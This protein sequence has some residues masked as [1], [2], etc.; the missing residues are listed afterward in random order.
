[1]NYRATAP[2]T[3][4]PRR[5]HLALLCAAALATALTACTGG[6]VQGTPGAAG[7]RDPYFPKL[8]NGGYDVRHYGLKLGYDPGSRHLTGTAE[9]TARA[10]KNLSAFNL[11][12]KGLDVRS[13]TVEGRKARFQRAGDELTV[14]P[15]EDLDRGETFRV[16]V[17]YSGTPRTI[18]DADGS[19]EG[20]LPA[21]DSA[22]ATGQPTGSMAWFPGNHHPSDKASYDIEVTV[23]KGLKA[24]SNGELTRQ[25]TSGGRT[26]FAWRNA[27]PMASY[28]ATVVVGDYDLKAST[29]PGKHGVPVL[30]AIDPT[31]P[32][33]Q[34]ERTEKVLADIPDIM[35][36]AE[37]NFGAYP[38]SST[39]AVVE[40][41]SDLGY[42]LETQTKPLFPVGQ[43]DTTTLVHELA[44]QWFGNSVTPKT[45]RDMWLNEGFATFAQ[46]LYEEDNGGDT[47]EETVDALYDGDLYERE[48]DNEA[49]W[50]FPPAKQPDAA[51]IS[52]D[53]VY[54]RGAMVIQ[55]VRE[56][57]GDDAFYEIVQG[58]TET[59]RHRT[60]D[61]EDF[62]AY[63]EEHAGDDETRAEL[64]RV[65]S[66]WLY[67]EG[68]PDE[69]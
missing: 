44:H 1:M 46:W 39:G 66:D 14:R 49:P 23:P 54:E 33:K 68:K 26:T 45:W 59:Y 61:T 16:T 35:E 18:T 7:V 63:V 4:G 62:T 34:Y 15:H 5:T 2:L 10:A 27:E 55:K 52:D 56:T 31:L 29:T 36:W 57:V 21:D 64:R 48:E 43:A 9:I 42:A 17:R 22:L 37:T 67:G 47:V 32:E 38:F 20:W 12:L 60:A 24:L 50:A 65:W 30:T 69:R 25:T 8:G 53:P 19:K 11:D 41:R 40:G 6:G 13:V 3:K 58:W 51:S 28:L